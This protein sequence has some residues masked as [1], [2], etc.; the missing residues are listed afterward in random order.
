[1]VP[2]QGPLLTNEQAITVA[3]LVLTAFAGAE[4]EQPEQIHIRDDIYTYRAMGDAEPTY[5]IHLNLS[6]WRA[7]YRKD[8]HFIIKERVSK[9]LRL[10]V[11]FGVGFIDY[12][13]QAGYD[14][15]DKKYDAPLLVYSSGNSFDEPY[16][17]EVLR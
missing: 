17:R 6:L 14:Y 7:A 12:K 8:R 16:C 15:S 2:G 11:G 5:I 4:S 13:A 1:M 3:R 9:H 10:T